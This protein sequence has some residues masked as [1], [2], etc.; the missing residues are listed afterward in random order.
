MQVVGQD[1]SNP[2]TA[3]SSMFLFL[4]YLT[5]AISTQQVIQQQQ[6]QMLTQSKN[7]SVEFPPFKIF[8]ILVFKSR[9]SLRNLK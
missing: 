5:D 7:I 2:C 3:T 8:I 9:T 1:S 6:Q 4:V